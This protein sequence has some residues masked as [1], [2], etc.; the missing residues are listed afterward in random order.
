MPC[1]LKYVQPIFS[2]LRE[3]YSDAVLFVCKNGI[4]NYTFPN[5]SRT[6]PAPASASRKPAAIAGYTPSTML[7]S[8]LSFLLMSRATLSVGSL[9][10]VR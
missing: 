9:R 2:F 1:I 6:I 10:P 3:G 7:A 4:L 5:A 8:I